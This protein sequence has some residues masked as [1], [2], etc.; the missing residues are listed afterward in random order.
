MLSNDIIEN[1][2]EVKKDFIE[3]GFII[4]GIFGSF[5]RGDFKFSALP[6]LKRGI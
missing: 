3:D 2:K 4:D 6:Y 1:L 5:A